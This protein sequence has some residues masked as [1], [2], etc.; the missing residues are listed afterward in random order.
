[1]QHNLFI[2]EHRSALPPIYLP[3]IL[4]AG[5]PTVV[6][7]NVRRV[8]RY[9]R[10]GATFVRFRGMGAAVPSQPW[11]L[12]DGPS[13]L[14]VRCRDERRE[15]SYGQQ[16]ALFACFW[17][18]WRLGHVELSIVAADRPSSLGVES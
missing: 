17:E 11:P 5:E 12:F 16:R 15:L 9:L 2:P 6:V 1:M 8:R 7:R 18:A 14:Y 3:F 4:E 10:E 13:S